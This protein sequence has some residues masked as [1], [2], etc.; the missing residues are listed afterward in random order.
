MRRMVDRIILKSLPFGLQQA[1]AEFKQYTTDTQSGTT[2]CRVV[3]LGGL[4]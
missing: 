1:S 2:Y 3:A 4:C